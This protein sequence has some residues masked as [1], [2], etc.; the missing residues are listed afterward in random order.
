[1]RKLLSVIISIVMSL[2]CLAK[3]DNQ[4]IM[5]VDGVEV[6]KPE[7]EYF[8]KKNFEGESISKKELKKYAELFLD[9]KLKVRAAEDAGMD[10][11]DSFLE[12]FRSYRN[13]QAE[14]Y[15]VDSLFLEEQ[16]KSTFKASCDEIGPDGL[17]YMCLIAI[18]P[19]DNT[20]AAFDKTYALLDSIYGCLKN[21]QDF[22][23]LAQKYSQDV[24]APRGGQAGWMSRKQLPAVLGDSLFSLS[25]G[26]F[27][28]PF[29][30]EN[31]MV[32]VSCIGR[33]ELGTYGDNRDG[34]YKWMREES[35]I[36]S[37]A[38]RRKANAYS[39]KYG[40]GVKDDVAVI[41]MDSLLETIVPEFANISREYHDGLLLFEI[42]NQLVWEKAANDSIGLMAYYESHKQDLWKD[43]D[44]F[45]GMVFFCKNE[46][47]YHDIEAA[48]AGLPIEKWSD[49]IVTFNRGKANVR[50]MRSSS[51]SGIFEKGQNAYVDNLVFGEGTIEP[52][53]NYP[54][55][56]V[57]G[58][59]LSQPESYKDATS[60]VVEEY[61]AA[62]EKE[63]LNQ[64]RNK[65]KYKIYKK[66]LNKV[67]L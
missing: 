14:E 7:F 56:N 33:R 26:S 25:P 55:V 46:N 51:Q 10:Q 18:E 6:L 58:K 40:W 11:T 48:V 61:Q 65:Y 67:S 15:M 17:A 31:I 1:M 4:V 28:R 16:A 66:A 2:P 45:K 24:S 35:D 13:L 34:I 47:V 36:Y 9:F 39:E 32:I 27:S 50:V 8:L 49:T 60:I 54:Y 38:M 22:G 19:E 42:S 37:E 23:P 21:G 44:R 64:L 59:R 57:I 30:V 12:E 63:W 5:T 20:P 62:I 3:T 41:Y 53:Q 29:P 52:M 43:C